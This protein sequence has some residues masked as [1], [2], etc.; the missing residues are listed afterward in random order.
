MKRKL[1]KKQKMDKR[2]FWLIHAT[3]WLGAFVF[4]FSFLAVG[5]L[6]FANDSAIASAL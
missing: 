6:F 4:I 2:K 5:Y 3:H 1:T